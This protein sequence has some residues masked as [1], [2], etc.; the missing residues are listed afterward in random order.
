MLLTL[1]LVTPVRLP[2]AL[3]FVLQPFFIPRYAIAASLAF[4]IL[5]GVGIVRLAGG[6]KRNAVLLTLL[7]LL[8]WQP[9]LT[10]YYRET[11]KTD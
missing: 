10:T 5:F 2:W 3:S 6:G 4:Y 9:D 8:W 11:H 7:A 1:W